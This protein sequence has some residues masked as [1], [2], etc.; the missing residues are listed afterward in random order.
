M[1]MLSREEL[2]DSLFLDLPFSTTRACPRF[3]ACGGKRDKCFFPYSSILPVILAS[4][5]F[6]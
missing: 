5:H 4:L 2:C 3:L 6:Q 1:G